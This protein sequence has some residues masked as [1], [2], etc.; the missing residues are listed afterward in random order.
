[1]HY[2]FNI[3]L[4]LYSGFNR[5]L[6]QPL[7]SYNNHEETRV[8]WDR[9]LAL[10]SRPTTNVTMNAKKR[11][12]AQKLYPIQAF[13]HESSKVRGRGK[14]EEDKHWE[15]EARRL[16][17]RKAAQ[18]TKN[19]SEEPKQGLHRHSSGNIAGGATFYYENK[20]LNMWHKSKQSF[21]AWL[22]QKKIEF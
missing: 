5:C 15:Q 16:M 14:R 9:N 6:C 22:I 11:V 8:R 19:T 3:R 1:M 4:L 18:Q 10:C 20:K 21:D 12:H 17:K 7:R 2:H 13:A